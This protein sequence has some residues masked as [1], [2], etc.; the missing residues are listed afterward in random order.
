MAKIKDLASG[1][2]TRQWQRWKE[3]SQVFLILVSLREK[4][5][6]TTFLGQEAQPPDL[7]CKG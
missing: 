4:K 3:S 6:N 7:L 5:I 1:P 2:G